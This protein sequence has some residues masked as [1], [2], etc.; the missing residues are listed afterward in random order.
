MNFEV[1]MAVS[2]RL[3]QSRVSALKMETTCSS[4]TLASTYETT[5][6]QNPRQHQ[7]YRYIILFTYCDILY[8]TYTNVIQIRRIVNF[9]LFEKN[10]ISCTLLSMQHIPVKSSLSLLFFTCSN[11]TT[12]KYLIKNTINLV[13]KIKLGA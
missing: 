10:T 6:S 4:E 13:M 3:V 11:V 7:Q 2:I 5:L 1:L 9:V 8:T 12:F